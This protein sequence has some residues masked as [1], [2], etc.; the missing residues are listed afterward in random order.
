[1]ASQKFERVTFDNGNVRLVGH[2]FKPAAGVG[3]GVVV[4]GSWT[5]VKEQM[6]DH[7]AAKLAEQ[8]LTALT[9]DFT[10]YGESGGDIREF[11]NPLE[12]VKDIS[13]AARWLSGILGEPVGGLAICASAGYMSYAIAEGAPIAAFASVAAWLHNPETVATVY[14]GAEGVRQRTQ[15]GEAA[16]KLYQDTG[17]VHHVP[18][19]SAT[20]PKAG[21]G[22][23]VGDYYSNPATGAVPE[24]SNRLAVL[25]WPE[26]LGYD[27]SARAKEVEIP[28]LMIHSEDAAFP[29]NVRRFTGMLAGPHELLWRKGTQTDFY[30]RPEQGAA[31]IS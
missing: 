20:D 4:T 3:P 13:A 25:S 26:W 2:L 15:D 1:M 12:K 29:E 19:Y 31:R 8:G 21:M 28:T 5:T 14:G 18:A 16:R 11:E 6:A 30:Y 24:W 17:V 9:F 22:T 27:G 10:H 7:Y 23:A